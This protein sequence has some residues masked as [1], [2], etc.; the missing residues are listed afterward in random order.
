MSESTERGTIFPGLALGL[1]VFTL[2]SLTS[3][4]C[5][6]HT[7]SIAVTALSCSSGGSF[8]EAISNETEAP[9]RGS[10]QSMRNLLWGERGKD[11]I[12]LRIWCSSW[13]KASKTV[14]GTRQ[15]P[16]QTQRLT[17]HQGVDMG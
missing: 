5:P 13:C 1:S 15:I 7:C 4:P 16:L 14:G 11:I 9:R 3:L 6:L 10:S 2:Q 8:R 17:S 12:E